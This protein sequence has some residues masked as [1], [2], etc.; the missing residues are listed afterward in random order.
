M[1]YLDYHATTPVDPRVTE[2]VVEFMTTQFGNASSVDHA[3][4]DRARRAVD[5][6]KQQI[7][8]L[9]HCRPQEIIFTSGATESVNLAIQGTVLA[10]EKQQKIPRIAIS[11]VEHKAVLDTCQILQKQGHIELLIL[12]VDAQANLNINEIEEVCRQ[13]LDLLCIMAANNEVGTIYPIEKIAAIAKRH[14]VPFFCDASQAIGKIPINFQDWDITMLALSGHKLYAPQ[15]VGAL[16]RKT[17]HS[18][19]PLFL[20]G[21]QQQ[22]L[23]PGTFNLPGIVGL[24][25]ACRLRGLEMEEDET[26][27]ARKRDNLQ[28]RLQEAIPEMIVNGNQSQRLA[29]NLHIAIPDIPNS[30]II[31]RI[32]EQIAISTGSACSSGTIVPSHVLRAMNLPPDL[33][34]GALRIGIG[35]FITDAEIEQAADILIQMIQTVRSSLQSS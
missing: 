2:K 33:I 20:G 26:E 1:I 11:A 24:G 21:G 16:I 32:R 23:R 30:T 14:A 12:T 8:D 27:I 13:G 28:T 34:D 3:V 31:A 5:Q 4:G 9:I 10:L 22:G 25:E 19:E 7:A 18:L 6:G 17:N 29:G 35:K 15:G